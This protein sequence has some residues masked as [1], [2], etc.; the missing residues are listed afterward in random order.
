MDRDQIQK[1]LD[2]H[3]SQLQ[4]ER[5]K[6]LDK[7][8]KDYGDKFWTEG[9]DDYMRR[10]E[11]LDEMFNERQSRDESLDSGSEYRGSEADWDDE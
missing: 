6:I 5:G 2:Q 9:I 11:Q 7:L 3:I 8:M 4:R 10:R 1:I